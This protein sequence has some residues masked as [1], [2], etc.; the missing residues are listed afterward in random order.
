MAMQKVVGWQIL[1]HGNVENLCKEHEKKM[2]CRLMATVQGQHWGECC[3]CRAGDTCRV[4]GV[5]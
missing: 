4:E 2:E 5:A 3:E 1:P